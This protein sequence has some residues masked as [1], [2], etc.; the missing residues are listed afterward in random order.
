MFT[1]VPRQRRVRPAGDEPDGVFL[2]NGPDD[3]APLTTPSKRARWSANVPVFGI[4]LGHQI[5]GLAQ[6]RH[7][8]QAEVRPSRR[9]P[10]GAKKLRRGRIEITSQNH[11]FA[12]DPAVASGRTSR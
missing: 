1:V 6:R 8:L 7:D 9:E 10:S 12:V 2:S 3:P 5:L 4:C 11:G